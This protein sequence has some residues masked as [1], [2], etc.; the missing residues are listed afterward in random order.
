MV[1]FICREGHSTMIQEI[2]EDLKDR[3]PSCIVVS[4]GGGGLALGLLKGL[5]KVGWNKVPLLCMETIGT[6]CFNLS[7]KEERLVVLDKLTSVAKTL[8]A[9]SVILP[10]LE[11]RKNFELV[12]EVLPDKDAVNG[13]I[14]LAGY[15]PTYNIN[16][17]IDI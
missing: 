5:E 17:I 6:E 11:A 16:F 8:G 3:T 1:E 14:R 13:C 12:S 10:L 9:R 15:I 2:K 7:L 4:I